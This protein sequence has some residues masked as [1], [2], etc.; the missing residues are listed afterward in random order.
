MCGKP[1]T[2][3]ENSAQP[4]AAP[5]EAWKIQTCTSTLNEGLWGW[6][7]TLGELRLPSQ[8]IMS[9]KFDRRSRPRSP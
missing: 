2:R 6:C 8:G 3:V 1:L 4:P 9:V 7:R 5:H